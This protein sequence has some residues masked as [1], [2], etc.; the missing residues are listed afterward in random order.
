[1]HFEERRQKCNTEK[2][3]R[4]RRVPS[5]LLMRSPRFFSAEV[6]IRVKSLSPPPPLLSSPDPPSFSINVC[7]SFPPFP[8]SSNPLDETTEGC[9]GT[10]STAASTSSLQSASASAVGGGGMALL[11][12]GSVLLEVPQIERLLFTTYC[13][14]YPRIVEWSYP[15]SIYYLIKIHNDARFVS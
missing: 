1:M 4:R 11:S 3:T 5:C 10:L 15:K 9:G 14:S 6:G 7:P 13:W 8:S 12:V 2:R